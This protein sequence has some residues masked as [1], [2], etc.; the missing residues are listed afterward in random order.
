MSQTTIRCPTC[1]CHVKPKNLEKHNLLVHSPKDPSPDK[2][3]IPKKTPKLVLCNICGEKF[4]KSK[5][6][7]HRKKKH[8]QEKPP[9]PLIIISK[10]GSRVGERLICS[11]CNN[12]SNQLW[13]YKESTRGTVLICVMCKPKVFD[14]SFDKLD[15]LN[16]ASTGGGFESKRSK[17]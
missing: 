16:F 10:R 13:Q 11:N 15:A 3:D 1:N 17:F 8:P 2:K 4:K 6:K 7:Q 12:Y 5:I 14:R 9:E